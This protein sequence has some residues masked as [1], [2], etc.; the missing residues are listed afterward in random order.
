LVTISE[1]HQKWRYSS[2]SDINFNDIE[3]R[4]FIPHGAPPSQSVEIPSFGRP[5][6]ETRLMAINDPPE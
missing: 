6:Q 5:P 4:I 2:D 1:R 3:V